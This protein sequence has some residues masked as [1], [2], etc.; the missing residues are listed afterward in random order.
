M[1]SLIFKFSTKFS[2]FHLNFDKTVNIFVF[3]TVIFFR[4]NNITPIQIPSYLKKSHHPY[5]RVALWYLA[6]QST[7]LAPKKRNFAYQVCMK[8]EKV[9]VRYNFQYKKVLAAVVFK[10]IL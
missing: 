9:T 10:P 4:P 3:Q 2:G 5:K 6:T 1:L 7:K 8:G